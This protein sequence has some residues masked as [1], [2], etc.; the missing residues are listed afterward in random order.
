T[1]LINFINDC[2]SSIKIEKV[3]FPYLYIYTA[4]Q[5]VISAQDQSKVAPLRLALKRIREWKLNHSSIVA[6]G[7]IYSEKKLKIEALHPEQTYVETH[8]AV[9][10]GRNL[11]EISVVLRVIYDEFSAILL[12]DIEGD[13]LTEL[14]QLKTDFAANVVKIPHH[15][16]WPANGNELEILLELIDPEI[17]ILSVGSKN[18]HGHVKPE[19]FE[20]LINLK[21]DSSKR[22]SQF[23]CTEVTRTC[24]YSVAE[25]SQKGNRGL[26]ST[27]KCAGEIT[28][29]AEES[30]K[31][32]CKTEVQHHA[33]VVANLPYAACDD[34][35][36]LNN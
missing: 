32:E 4:Q 24:K 36:D 20:A 13:G 25:R 27:E 35:A 34:R 2:K 6:N 19:L 22:L 26:S 23:V 11:N 15:G 12:A 33:S 16:G 14:L 29:I 21:N 7:E 17:T 5:K 3:H 9:K 1:K 31:W 18:P 8:L 30:G 10:N 28:I